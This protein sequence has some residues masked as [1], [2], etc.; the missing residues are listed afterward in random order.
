MA[1]SR[2]VKLCTLPKSMSNPF[3]INLWILRGTESSEL[4][5]LLKLLSQL[6]L[7]CFKKLPPWIFV[8]RIYWTHLRINK[9]FL[10]LCRGLVY[11]KPG[12][13]D[14]NE[15]I[16]FL[17]PKTHLKKY[18]LPHPNPSTSPVPL[19][20]GS[21]LSWN[22]FHVTLK[23]GGTLMP[24]FPLAFRVSRFSANSQATFQ[25]ILSASGS[26][27]MAWNQKPCAQLSKISLCISTT[28][29]TGNL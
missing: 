4:R 21:G 16:F 19:F 2:P 3:H 14:T 26:K 29:I 27:G 17:A 12:H 22:S 1:R 8:Q 10:A 11:L 20:L 15:S 24:N 6:S 9:G 13:P 7:C 23:R 25:Q 5:W 18:L 28:F